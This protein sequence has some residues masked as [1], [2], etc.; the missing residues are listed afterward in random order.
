MSLIKRTTVNAV[1]SP[2]T[3]CIISLGVTIIL[4][5]EFVKNHQGKTNCCMMG[6]GA[7]SCTFCRANREQEYVHTKCITGFGIV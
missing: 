1:S 6:D 7:M 4:Y 3:V 2:S 5:T